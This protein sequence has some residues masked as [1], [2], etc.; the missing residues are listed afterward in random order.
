MMNELTNKKIRIGE[1]IV[2]LN[3]GLCEFSDS[4]S[5]APAETAEVRLEPRSCDVLRVLVAHHGEVVSKD[6][7]IT[8]VWTETYASDD[9]LL[10]TISRLRTSL[11]D[12]AKQPRYIETIPKRGYRLIAQVSEIV[13]ES[14]KLAKLESE[15]SS[16]SRFGTIAVVSTVILAAAIYFYMQ[17]NINVD[18]ES[19]QLLERA[20]DYYH[21]MR[22][23]DNE[24]AIVL[25][26]QIIEAKPKTA[27]A[28]AGMANA[29]V[30]RAIRYS[31]EITGEVDEPITLTDRVASGQLDS[32]NARAV[33]ARAQ[34]FADKA[35]A[36]EPQNP[37]ALK[38]LGFVL[39]AQGNYEEAIQVYHSALVI[40]PS[41]WQV[42]LNLGEL[43]EEEGDSQSALEMYS[44][45]FA[46]MGERYE[47]NTV[48]IRPW[49][50]AV[51]RMLGDIHFEQNRYLEAETWY[52]QALVIEPL[53]EKASLGLVNVLIQTGETMRARQVCQELNA[54]L[55]SA[56]CNYTGIQP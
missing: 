7:L 51:A 11:G 3:S 42:L 53:H 15:N 16:R 52:R 25:Y 5:T 29:L 31:T 36:L 2:D 9:S 4:T 23:A 19:N 13:V 18:T 26:E 17:I 55:Q 27:E 38:A 34:S 30:Q 41:A 33:L 6:D 48:Q 45:A 12:N 32:N 24:R 40:D 28:Y 44:S 35:V 21:Q 54:R 47:E 14:S 8:A 1:W 56:V 37:V 46:A 43:Y 20:D 50:A 49:Y 10:R 39:S 22:L